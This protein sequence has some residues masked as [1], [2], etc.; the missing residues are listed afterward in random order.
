MSDRRQVWETL[1]RLLK[2]LEQ[3]VD[4][5][6]QPASQPSSAAP[7]PETLATLESEVR[8]LGK[9]HF[10]ANMLAEKQTAQMEQAL[11]E[12]RTQ[13]QEQEVLLEALIAE[14]VAAEQQK[15]LEALLPV[16]DGLDQ[17][18]LHGQKY[19]AMRDKAAASP[20]LAP[21]QATLVS[22]SDRAKLA[23]W[24]DGLRLLRERLLQ[25]LNAGEVTAIPSVGHAFDPY[26]HVAVA[27]ANA[28]NTP[29][30]TIVSEER[31]GY[32][33]PQGILRYAEVVV[34]KRK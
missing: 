14:R 32:R 30:G 10:K 13:H 24:L 1:A 33:T 31:R 11:S 29:P 5:A 9:T 6:F 7:T 21:E 2:R 28:D 17:A 15:W 4:A 23:S 34:N 27:V 20:D 8:K 25:I 18:I 16:L 12:L 26:L 3:D 22:P 19:L